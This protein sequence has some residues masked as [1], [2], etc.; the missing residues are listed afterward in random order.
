MDNVYAFNL[1]LLR[2]ETENLSETI[3]FLTAGFGIDLEAVEERLAA[4]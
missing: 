1:L 4:L 3:R 2:D